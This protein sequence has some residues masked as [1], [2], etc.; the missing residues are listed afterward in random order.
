[1][2]SQINRRR[3]GGFSLLEVIVVVATVLVLLAV[4]PYF[5]ARG[6]RRISRVGCVTNLKQ[7]GLAA[8]MWSNDNSDRFP[9]Q[10]S[11]NQGGT[12]EFAASP[13]VFRHFRVMSNELNSPRILFC[14]NDRE[15][16]R[17]DTFF[18]TLA[19]SN[20]SYFVGLD[21]N[22]TRPQSIL[23]GDRN[24]MGGVTNGALL[25]FRSNDVP[26]WASSIHTNQGNLALG[27]G[28]VQQLADQALARRFQTT[29]VAQASIMPIRLA[30][31]RTP[32]D[33]LA[34]R[35]VEPSRR[36]LTPWITVG[37]AV[38]VIVAGWWLLR[39]R[40]LAGPSGPD[41]SP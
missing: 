16:L 4:V 28:S 12:M 30:I 3:C 14:P 25:S 1:M 19:N 10:V 15:R 23:T 29:F 7:V 34:G 2:N 36:W 8:R 5:A 26:G 13:E 6:N 21:A 37:A 27:D 17:A 18:Q 20:V 31:P 41:A 9:W 32:Q 35:R 40:L 22:E 39:R 11:T 33:A 24:I 38:V